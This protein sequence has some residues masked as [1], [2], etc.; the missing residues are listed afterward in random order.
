MDKISTAIEEGDGVAY[1]GIGNAS[2]EDVEVDVSL[3][4]LN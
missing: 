3:S 4:F 2:L 1:V